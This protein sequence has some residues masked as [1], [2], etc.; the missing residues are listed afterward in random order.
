MSKKIIIDFE[1]LKNP[2]TGLY[3]FSK[4]LGNALIENNNDIDLIFY[5][6][7][8]EK[9]LFNHCDFKFYKSIHNYIKPLNNFSWHNTYQFSKYG[10]FSK[11]NILTIHDLNYLIEKKG[12]LEKIKKYQKKVQK[13]VDK[14]T[15]IVCISE[16]VAN[17]VK[18][19]IDLK[20]KPIHVIYNGTN[21]NSFDNF[22]SPIYKPKRQFIFSL[23]TFFRKKNFHVLPKLLVDNDFELVIGGVFADLNYIEEIKN[24][25]KKLNVDDRLH[26]L[27]GIS[28]EEKD[29]YYKNCKLFAFPSLAEG[30]GL[31]VIEAMKY[32]K[33]VLSSKE[34]SLPEVGGNTAFY[35]EDFSIN[36]MQE[37]LKLALETDNLIYKQNALEQSLKFSWDNTAKQYLELYNKIL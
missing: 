12:D 18:E 37:T 21:I 1:R 16:F 3:T 11:P 29:W 7:K 5:L 8:K 14:A 28:D 34:C 32:G 24:E 13:N 27:N 33:K 4:D 36:S 20:N 26:L 22:D 2:Y 9:H 30:F 23:G 15:H 6:P 25:A 31:P 10:G 19:N 17:H 35:F